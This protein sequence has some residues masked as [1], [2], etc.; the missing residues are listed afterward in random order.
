LHRGLVL[1]A[2]DAAALVDGSLDGQRC[3]DVLAGLLTV[4]WPRTDRTLPGDGNDADPA[5]DVLLPFTGTGLLRVPTDS[6]A[7]N[8][9]VRP[10]PQWP[11]LLA[12]GRIAEVLG[13][14]ARRLRIAGLRHVIDPR[15]GDRDGMAL[16]AVLLLRIS[17]PDRAAALRRVAALPQA[18]PNQEITP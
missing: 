7:K 11:V 1:R 4:D 9:L 10:G 17:D 13:D 16:A 8:V 14:A 5:L 6:G 3:A 15:S 2:A 18:S 12:A